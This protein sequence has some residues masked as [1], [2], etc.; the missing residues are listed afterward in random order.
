LALVVA[1]RVGLYSV[2]Q[3]VVATGLKARL[4]SVVEEWREGTM[5]LRSLLAAFFSRGIVILVFWLITIL[6]TVQV[7]YR[8][9][10]TVGI[11]A[12]V[13]CALCYWGAAAFMGS[14]LE[15][16]EK[17][18]RPFDL[19]GIGALSLVI[20]AAGAALMIWSGFR[21]RLYGVEVEGVVWALLGALSAVV[22]V[23]KEDVFKGD[24]TIR[25]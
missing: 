8:S 18:Y 3:P 1:R 9:S 16:R 19:V 4:G 14:L 21:M 11:S 22:V 17:K 7:M 25:H 13:A 10:F 20:I 24:W 6:T 12:L 23:R 2:G 5:T 15:R